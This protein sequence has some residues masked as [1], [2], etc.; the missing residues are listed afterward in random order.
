MRHMRKMGLSLAAVS[1]LS[2]CGGGGGGG[3]VVSTAAAALSFMAE[4]LSGGTFSANALSTG[5]LDSFAAFEDQART[6]RESTLYQEQE[7]EWYVESDGTP[8][9]NPATEPLYNS[10]SLAAARV[11]YAHAAGITGAG[12][13]IA[14][15]DGDFLP[16]HEA[17]AGRVLSYTPPSNRTIITQEE[18]AHGTAVSSVA[19]GS[20]GSMIGVAYD[21]QLLLSSYSNAQDL[22]NGTNLARSQGAIVQNNS[23]GFPTIAANRTNFDT[24]FGTGQTFNGYLTALRNFTRDGVVVFAADNFTNATQS[25]IMESL[26]LFAPEL[27]AGWLAVISGVPTFDN[28]RILSAQ[29]VSAPCLQA[30]RWCLAADGTWR[31]ASADSDTSYGE[32]PVVGTSFAAPVVSGAIALLAQAFPNLTPHDLRARLIATADNRF[33]GFTASGTLEV[34]PG[35]GFFHD[36]S[37]EWGHGFLDVRAALLPIGTPVAR[38]ADGTVQRADQPLI[39][40]GG[41][42]GD[43]VARS[44]SAVPVLVTDMLGGDF[45]MPGEALAATAT[46]APVSERLWSAMFGRTPR[47]GLLREYGGGE[48]TLRQ[49]PVE[50]SLLGP[51]AMGGQTG[52]AGS[53]PAMAAAFGQVLDAAGG[54]LF[55]GLN[56]AR[57]DGTLLPGIGG[58]ASMLAAVD[59]AFTREVGR[60]G[61]VELGGT[62]GMSPGGT[63]AAMSDRS[64][65][66]FNA[67]RVEAGQTGVLRNGDRLSLGLSLPV[68]VTSGGARIAL[69]VSRSAAGI[70]H[71]D[72]GIDYAP[73]DREIDLSITYGTPFGPGGELFVGAIHA[74]NHGH[75]AGQQD[76]AAILGFRMAF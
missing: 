26:P 67:F 56:I 34:I 64:D 29:R 76:T 74:F 18:V 37:T 66:L 69:P 35:S 72:V 75:V 21:S 12:Q 48:M 38:M 15:V 47:S 8:G 41:A 68:A 60:G 62:F 71:R 7:I 5:F 23:W 31:A 33:A 42:S 6:L 36:Y 17:L 22:T 44:L 25:S 2:G 11:E 61:F 70:Q 45:T 20:S 54:E 49:G 58:T 32:N 50:L 39:A 73:Q 27:E 51:D 40:G 10:Y 59:V 14:I 43:A 52:L 16:T 53:D 4:T 65:V 3:G 57:D 13:I 24:Y 28:E 19:A 30:A 1:L 9:N 55:I 46:A 63:G